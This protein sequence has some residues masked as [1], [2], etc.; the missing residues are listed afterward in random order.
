MREY[1]I[2][3]V[4]GGLA[5][6]SAAAE[7]RE[8]S[9]QS[10]VLLADA[11]G[12]AS[13]EI[14][15]FSAPV[16]PPDSADAL[17]RDTLRSGGGYADPA[18]VRILA[19]RAVPEMER[20]IR[21]GVKFD[22]APDGRWDMVSAVGTSFPRVVH[23]GTTT[24][25]QAMALLKT[26][27]EPMRIVQ[28]SL[29]TNGIA[30]GWT[31]H[32]EFLRAKA[33]ILAGG[34]FAGLWRF[35]T[36][37]KNLRGDAILLAMQVGADTCGLGSV[38]FEPTVAVWPERLAGFPV[39]TTALNEGAKLLNRHGKSL[40]TPGESVP[41]KRELAEKILREI[42][43]GN[44]G[45]H[46][47]IRYDFRDVEEARFARKYPEYHAKFKRISPEFNRLWFEV[48]P[49]AHTTLGGIHIAPDCSTRVP[50]LFAAG[51][52]A[53]GIHGRDRL[54]GNAGLEVLVFGRIAGNSAR[55]YAESHPFEKTD[56]AFVRA[57]EPPDFPNRA[58]DLLDRYFHP[59]ST[60][61]E[62]AEG[63]ER[64]HALPECPRR[65]LIRLVFAD[66]IRQ[67]AHA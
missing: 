7:I 17:Y 24:G 62:L 16:N 66:G 3:I 41:C 2:L 44:A 63:Y 26:E 55:R 18:L 50:G 65:E 27:A 32:G 58:A 40:L 42:R 49:G 52:A 8:I 67:S 64:A 33:V 21:M 20:L 14:M 30:G 31:E 19:D 4:G 25:K 22:R 46:G 37:S 43:N 10:R 48:K 23:S 61:D 51:E 47:G 59:L 11:G 35:S 1:D 53:G 6:L 34:G 9:P 36:W 28:L 15:G 60:P 56:D 29:G 57:E 13:S 12:G 45:D 38:Q 5:G 54:G 39:I